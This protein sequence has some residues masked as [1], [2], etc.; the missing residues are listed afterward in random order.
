VIPNCAIALLVASKPAIE[1]MP[2]EAREIAR[3]GQCPEAQTTE[4]D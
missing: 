4:N 3:A 2:M 1:D